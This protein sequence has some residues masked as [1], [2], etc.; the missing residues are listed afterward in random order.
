[1]RGERLTDEANKPLGSIDRA[2]GEMERRSPLFRGTEASPQREL[3]GE[4]RKPKVGDTVSISNGP[5]KGS[6][7]E[8][9]NVT[10]EGGV[11]VR[12]EE[13]SRV[14]YVKKGD[15]KVSRDLTSGNTLFANPTGKP[16]RK[17][18]G[19]CRGYGIRR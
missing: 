3:L 6:R 13:N 12:G 9:T 8:V 4:E 19:C 14:R 18:R 11:Y 17:V 10:Q 16:P 15:Y 1:M 2:A 7:A 5:L